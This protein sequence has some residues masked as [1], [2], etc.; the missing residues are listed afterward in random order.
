MVTAGDY[1]SLILR[2]F[3]T[4]IKDIKAWGGEDALEPRFGAV[5]LSIVFEDDVPTSTRTV[6]KSAITDLAEQLSIISF[7][8]V[9][10]DPVTTFI[11]SNVYFQFNPQLTT[12]SLNSI[13]TGVNLAV[14]SYF[15]STV[16]EFNQAFRRSNL[17]T[18][19]DAVSPAVLSSRADIK[20]QQRIT[21]TPGTE[22]TFN[23]RFPVSIA[24]PDDAFY[25]VTT[26]PFIYNAKTCIIR[27]RLNSNK[28]EI[29]SVADG[30]VYI[31][32]IGSYNTSNNTLTIT[33]FEPDSIIGGVDYL[34]IS[35]VPA[36]QSSIVPQLND[37]V[38]YDPAPSFTSGITTTSI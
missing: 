15:T 33:G 27:N 13:Q 9:F 26:T 35:V 14:E 36:N 22:L 6:T 20:M 11:E 38:I 19:V 37:I 32:N 34:K 17:L 30:T 16:G 18:E 3:G 12:L 31:D 25:I 24:D 21:P 28:L 7:D 8:I 2:N 10:E 23:L 4:L 29:V 1:S 5:Y